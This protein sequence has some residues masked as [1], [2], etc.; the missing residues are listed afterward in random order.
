MKKLNSYFIILFVGM[1]LSCVHT[2]PKETP[3]ILTATY[4][5]KTY[6][7]TEKGYEVY[8][9]LKNVMETTTVKGVVLKNKYFENIELKHLEGNNY[10]V[11][12]YFPVNSQTIINFETPKSDS[13]KDGIIFEISGI[14]KF[15]EI[16]F[17]LK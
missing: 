11:E 7:E 16:N 12:Q 1:I 8:L 5:I 9:T 17:K 6:S 2:L 3:E 10:F 13:R 14:E 4:K 15:K